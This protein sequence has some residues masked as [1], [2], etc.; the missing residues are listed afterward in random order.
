MSKVGSSCLLD[1]TRNPSH[2]VDNEEMHARFTG[3]LMYLVK[4]QQ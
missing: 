3:P 4:V 1:S 2:V